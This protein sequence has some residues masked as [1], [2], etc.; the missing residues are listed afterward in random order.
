M[1]IIEHINKLSQL[2]ENESFAVLSNDLKHDNLLVYGDV[3]SNKQS[4][5]NFLN[6]II[7]ERDFD[8][9]T[10]PS[11]TLPDVDSFSGDY[12]YEY[13]NSLIVQVKSEGII[14]FDSIE[15]KE[16]LFLEYLSNK[17]IVMFDNWE[18]KNLFYKQQ[19]SN[20]LSEFINHDNAK[21]F[22]DSACNIIDSTSETLKNIVENIISDNAFAN[23]EIP[24]LALELKEDNFQIYN[25]HLFP[26][27]EG[28]QFKPLFDIIIEKLRAAG[29]DGFEVMSDEFPYP[30]DGRYIFE[31]SKLKDLGNLLEYKEQYLNSIINNEIEIGQ[32]TVDI[33]PYHTIN[34]GNNLDTRFAD[35]RAIG[36]NKDGV[37]YEGFFDSSENK[38]TWQSKPMSEPSIND[39]LFNFHSEQKPLNPENNNG[40]YREIKLYSTDYSG[41]IYITEEFNDGAKNFKT[42]E[43]PFISFYDASKKL[44][45]ELL[46]KYNKMLKS[47]QIIPNR[48]VYGELL[49]NK[50]TLRYHIG[51]DGIK[52]GLEYSYYIK[53]TQTD[54][55]VFKTN[56]FNHVL[57]EQSQLAQIKYTPFEE[58][59]DIQIQQQTDKT[60]EMIDRDELK[61]G[62][63][64]IRNE[65]DI[66]SFQRNYDK[67][68]ELFDKLNAN[69]DEIDQRIYMQINTPEELI[70]LYDNKLNIYKTFI[71]EINELPNLPSDLQA[72]VNNIEQKYKSV[73]QQKIEE[74]SREIIITADSNEEQNTVIE[75]NTTKVD[76]QLF[77]L[78]GDGEYIYMDTDTKKCISHFKEIISGADEPTFELYS[79][80]K[81]NVQFIKDQLEDISNPQFKEFQV[82][83]SD[84]LNKV[85]YEKGNLFYNHDD[86]V[87]MSK[88]ELYY[89][90]SPKDGIVGD[91]LYKSEA[92]ELM[93]EMGGVFSHHPMSELSEDNI[94]KHLNEFLYPSKLD[95]TINDSLHYDY[96]LVDDLLQP[97]YFLVDQQDILIRKNLSKD[98]IEKTT[99][100]LKGDYKYY[101]MSQFDSS[102]E[103]NA[104]NNGLRNSDYD[105]CSTAIIGLNLKDE[106]LD[107]LYKHIYNLN[108]EVRK[109]LFLNN[110][111]F[112]SLI[113]NIQ[114]QITKD[115]FSIAIEKGNINLIREQL[116]NPELK[117]QAK[118]LFSIIQ[119]DF[120]LI[121]LKNDNPNIDTSNLGITWEIP[122]IIRKYNTDIWFKPY[123]ENQENKL[124]IYASIVDLKDFEAS[125]FKSSCVYCYTIDEAIIDFK[126]NIT[127]DNSI[128]NTAKIYKIPF[129]LY[130]EN[131]DLFCCIDNNYEGALAVNETI[132]EIKNKFQLICTSNFAQEAIE[133]LTLQE[134]KQFTNQI[135][136]DFSSIDIYPNGKIEIIA[137]YLKEKDGHEI[138]FMK[139]ILNDL[140]TNNIEYSS[141]KLS[142]DGVAKNIITIHENIK[143][144]NPEL[145][146]AVIQCFDKYGIDYSETS[147]TTL[148]SRL[149]NEKE[150]TYAMVDVKNKTIQL[151]YDTIGNINFVDKHLKESQPKDVENN[152]AVFKV[153]K[154]LF[155][156]ARNNSGEF[157]QGSLDYIFDHSINKDSFDNKLVDKIIITCELVKDLD[158]VK[159]YVS[160]LKQDPNIEISTE[161]KKKEIIKYQTQTLNNDKQSTIDKNFVGIMVLDVFKKDE[162]SRP[163]VNKYIEL[164]GNKIAKAVDT[165]MS[166]RIE[167]L[168]EGNTLNT[169]IDMAIYI[170]SNNPE[171]MSVFITS[172]QDES[173][174]IALKVDSETLL[175]NN[176]KKLR[177]DITNRSDIGPNISVYDENG[178]KVGYGYD[179][180][181]LRANQTLRGSLGQKQYSELFKKKDTAQQTDQK[182]SAATKKATTAK[183][184]PIKA[185]K[186]AAKMQM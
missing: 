27:T 67:G 114:D 181:S 183:S 152:C 167:E 132:S 98:E 110:I 31:Q 90:L 11:D 144:N 104:F 37:L 22:D 158:N 70:N 81:S 14:I 173:A 119:H 155:P 130:V 80:E 164:E 56:D 12:A 85:I 131:N 45:G 162:Y 10:L 180:L 150:F 102:F 54:E 117:L 161:Q 97:K 77:I 134:Q 118:H 107:N 174:Y 177:V 105:L 73:L 88:V 13:T 6:Q 26:A 89:V 42:D 121:K 55:I 43:K 172:K 96:I 49:N 178:N 148:K 157:L 63:N 25:Y 46:E 95:N 176:L 75:P 34:V 115:S 128:N 23:S 135:K 182:S 61:K 120:S 116:N 100:S 52:N 109:E 175:N 146:K 143:E 41:N 151:I 8:V 145:Q 30:T 92:F 165:I 123:A 139:S 91:N 32:N 71:Q 133:K 35:Y 186:K 141:D 137:S 185:V 94:K 140:K 59:N 168:K 106:Y 18:D 72:S 16:Q 21:V 38:H 147:L 111:P 47:I 19:N 101:L 20:S 179:A 83:I 29:V 60:V 142:K 48:N 57:K 4:M 3:F 78:M 15:F 154:D 113:S 170:L 122:D 69:I 33:T 125:G 129:K 64:E 62:F 2:K 127:N 163:S 24:S 124:D 39:L 112:Q 108:T 184:E 79:I 76:E 171:K 136:P 103:I 126:E 58:Y 44:N 169:K 138:I 68:K 84:N 87:E 99:A 160:K 53:D 153:D 74:E 28:T 149:F 17:N 40:K 86:L 93:E 7:N 82:E 1:T 66:T 50:G 156:F 166:E 9:Y 65:Y 51:S 5:S 159:D 36:Y